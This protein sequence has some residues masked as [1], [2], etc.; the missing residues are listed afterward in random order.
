MIQEA[1]DT[2]FHHEDTVI[3]LTGSYY[4]NV[5]YNG[6]S[7]LVTSSNPDDANTVSATI[8][9]AMGVGSVVS[10]VSGEDSGCRLAGFTIQNGA[11]TETE[12]AGITVWAGGGIFCRDSSPIV[13]KCI[14]KQNR[15][16]LGGGIFLSNSNATI[17]NCEIYSNSATNATAAGF[18]WNSPIRK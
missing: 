7:I 4:E 18:T 5:N 14:I 17:S 10:I 2:A 16:E 9:D 3:V 6:K 11:G 1:I 12:F 8:I 15:P 13:E